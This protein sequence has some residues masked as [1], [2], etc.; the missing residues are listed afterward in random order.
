[1]D[2]LARSGATVAGVLLLVAAAGLVAAAIDGSVA[3]AGGDFG[4]VVRKLQLMAVIALLIERAVEVYLVLTRQ[5]GPVAYAPAVTGS[6]ARPADRAALSAAM[7]LAFVFSLSGLRIV[8]PA[9]EVGSPLARWLID[10]ADVVIS[11]GLMAGGAAV[12]HEVIEWIREFIGLGR[13][14]NAANLEAARQRLAMVE[15]G[16]KDPDF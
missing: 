16:A 10:A 3:L 12:V 13:L 4:D 2:G 11:A 5:N 14:N 8:G 1:M 7:T 9:L 6:A 15:R